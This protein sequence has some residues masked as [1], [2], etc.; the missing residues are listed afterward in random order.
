[1]RFSRLQKLIQ[2]IWCERLPLQLHCSSYRREGASDIGRY[3]ITLDKDIIW[4]APGDYYKVL[5]K[6]ALDHTATEV[7]I[8]LREYLDCPR[9]EL[10]TREF[11]ADQFG[12]VDVMRAADRRIGLKKLSHLLERHETDPARK[13]LEAR[14]ARVV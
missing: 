6:D 7:T 8:V 11:A 1:M 5:D 4:Q 10:L 2:N 12:L 13:V 14:M 9:E 3:W